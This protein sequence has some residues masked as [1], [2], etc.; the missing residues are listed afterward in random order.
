MPTHKRFLHNTARRKSLSEQKEKTP[1]SLKQYAEYMHMIEARMDYLETDFTVFSKKPIET[2]EAIKEKQPHAAIS[3]LKLMSINEYIANGGRQILMSHYAI[4]ALLDSTEPST[5]HSTK[6]IALTGGSGENNYDS[7]LVQTMTGG[8]RD[9]P[10]RIRI[11]SRP[12]QNILDSG[13]NSKKKTN[14]SLDDPLVTLR[15]F[16]VL[17][18]HEG[19]IRKHLA[20]LD[21]KFGTT[22]DQAS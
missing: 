2:S 17:I 9:L 21:S 5:Q 11:N 10:E 22:V 18:Y 19:Q 8:E 14:S 1:K 4:D 3:Q 6:Q 15:P 12:V 7:E 20:E 16:K 13:T